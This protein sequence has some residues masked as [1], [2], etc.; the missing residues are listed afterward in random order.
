MEEKKK[1]LT[2]IRGNDNVGVRGEHFDVLFSE[3]AGA[4]SAFGMVSYR[5]AGKEL[6]EEIPRPNFWRAPTDNDTGNHMMARQGQW[7]LASLYASCRK[8][9]GRLNKEGEDFENPQVR[10][11]A[12][13]VSVSYLYDLNTTPAATCRLTYKVY[14]DGSV[15][16]T[17]A[18]DPVEGLA[19]MP[20]FGVLFKLNADYDRLEWYGNG[21]EETYADRDQ[22]AKLGVYRNRVA[23]NMAAYLV[24]QECGNKTKV[25]WAKV[26]DMRGRGMLFSGENLNFSALP[27][28]PHEVENARHP[29]ELPPVHYTVVRVAGGQLGVGGDDSWGA[30][31]HPEYHLDV[32]G[33]KEFSF[34]FRGV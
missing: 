1:P 33:K 31:V 3:P 8:P 26:T 11:E 27:Y 7:K 24:P 19:D 21:P 22:G 5:Y 28:T 29:Y 17:L 32:S 18:Y 25:R 15:Q 30:P 34:T 9:G 4:I 16:T 12:D 10:E 6:I 2:I 13:H 23:D 14:G 20:E